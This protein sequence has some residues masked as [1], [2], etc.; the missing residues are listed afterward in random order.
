MSTAANEVHRRYMKCFRAFHVHTAMQ[1]LMKA[2]RQAVFLAHGAV[3]EP[4]MA[5]DDNVVTPDSTE[6]DREHAKTHTMLARVQDGVRYVFGGHQEI[7]DDMGPLT[8]GASPA[9]DVVKLTHLLGKIQE[10][11]APKM[12]WVRDEVTPD[13][14]KAQLAAHAKADADYAESLGTTAAGAEKLEK[15][16]ELRPVSQQIWDI[17]LTS[18]VEANVDNHEEQVTVW[19]IER[20][21]RGRKAASPAPE[22]G[23]QSAKGAG[24]G[25][26][27]GGGE[28]VQEAADGSESGE[29]ASLTGAGAGGAGK[30][31]EK[32][33]AGE[34]LAGGEPGGKKV[35]AASTKKK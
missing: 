13:L 5:A 27:G 3:L 7:L 21:H 9:E 6:V 16:R 11:V 18:W 15:L 23:G 34:A 19:G 30:A 20:R 1:P 22:P 33:G 24:T 29:T 2:S 12:L 8:V 25:G 26:Q 32:P 14:I 4:L 28:S 17:W 35:A 31:A 10:V